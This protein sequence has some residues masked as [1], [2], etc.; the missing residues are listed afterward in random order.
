MDA[1]VGLAAHDVESSAARWRARNGNVVGAEGD[2][3]V[4]A[5]A[6]VVER[7]HGRRRGAEIA[8]LAARER[9]RARGL[10]DDVSTRRRAA[11]KVGLRGPADR[12]GESLGEGLRG[13]QLPAATERLD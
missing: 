4:A 13:P 5:V 1:A 7:E 2:R 6:V 9:A 3:V 8:D 10:V 12:P 11:G